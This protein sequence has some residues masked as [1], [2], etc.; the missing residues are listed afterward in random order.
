MED[1][2]A[3]QGLTFDDVLLDLGN[4]VYNQKHVKQWREG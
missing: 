2:I 1:R 3:F 4:S